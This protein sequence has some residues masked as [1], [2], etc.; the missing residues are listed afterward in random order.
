[1][2]KAAFVLL[3]IAIALL[4]V[5][6]FAQKNIPLKSKKFDQSRQNQRPQPT[7]TISVKPEPKFALPIAE[8]EKR[9]TKKPFGIYITPQNSPVQ[10]ERFSGYHTGVDVEYEDTTTQVPVYAIC[11]GEIVLRQWVGGYGATLILKCQFEN[12]AIYVLYGHLDSNSFTQNSQVNQSVQIAIL[13]EGQTQTTDF[14]RKH[15]HLSISKNKLD[16]RGYVDNESELNQWLD[17]QE[18]LL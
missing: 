10:P 3:L 14:E 15:L 13:G 2:K 16:L 18:L 11:D 6:N 5:I 8:F 7:P 17:P 1:M 12:Q 4:A 9:I